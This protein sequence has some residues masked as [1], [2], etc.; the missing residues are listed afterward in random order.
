MQNMHRRMTAVFC[1][2]VLLL[3]GMIHRVYYLGASDYLTAAAQVQG[4]Y[5]INVAETRGV[6]YDRNRKPL[7]GNQYK[8]VASVLPTPEAAGVLLQNADDKNH[9]ALLERLSDGRPFALEVTDSNLYAQGVDVF[10]VPERY[11]GVAYAPHLI[12]YL[13]DGDVG[14]AGIERAFDQQ[15]R[16]AGGTI[17]V[18]YQMDALGQMMDA[19]A[20][21]VERSEDEP[22]G[23]VVL[24]LDRELQ[25][26]VQT[27]LG[28][29]C[30]KGAAVVL[31]VE[32]GD[33]LAM[34]SLPTF[35]QTDIAASLDRTD[36]PFV[37]RATSGYNIGS[38][39]KV[40]VAAGALE[41]GIS[42]YHP[43][44]CKG[45]V[46]LDGQIFR[47]NNSAVHGA[48]D[49]RRALAVSCNTYFIELAQQIPPEDLLA[50][51]RNLGL[52]ASQELAD[53]L[54]TQAGN[55]PTIEE[56]S[57]PA[58][59]ANFSFGQG[60]SLAS[61]LQMAQAIAAIAGG[62]TA[63]QPRLVRGL[64]ADGL[65]MDEVPAD[66]MGT[67][68]FSAFTAEVMR[69][70]MVAVVEEGS[71]KPASPITGSAGGKTSSAQTGQ[72][73]GTGAEKKEIVHAWFAGFYPAEKPQYVI[74]VFVE[75]G[76]SGERV[77][78]PIFKQIADSITRTQ[79]TLP[80]NP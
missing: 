60:S 53:G 61:P 74:V 6:I 2:M 37:N 23:G 75:G 11:G 31:E 76:V 15:L 68:V 58:G 41:H 30:E 39:F 1:I 33:I 48:V 40:L 35:D 62:G 24:T 19:H 69:E 9:A 51:C 57:T 80:A 22:T 78:A 20:V 45:Y 49:M 46:D 73:T 67:Q 13:G 4:K 54:F 29:G 7:V 14:V 71:G 32:S 64:T 77:A 50:L 27:A 17:S 12:G 72:Y 25:Q 10:R 26:A 18:L 56:L 38:V 8:Y 65:N 47:C 59:Y 28:N 44:E 5:R 36:A 63:K 79:I 70:L 16:Q 3:T 21:D 42:Q 43:Y 34:A 52:N 66:Y 55:L